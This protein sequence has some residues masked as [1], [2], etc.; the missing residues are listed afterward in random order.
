MHG[1]NMKQYVNSVIILLTAVLEE[2]WWTFTF[3]SSTR[4]TE[5]LT[6]E[7]FLKRFSYVL[8]Q[9]SMLRQ[10]AHYDLAIKWTVS[11]SGG[12]LQNPF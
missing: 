8:P 9:N 3:L 12:L 4:W 7:Q 2:R 10:L 1:L 5:D 11:K 6:K